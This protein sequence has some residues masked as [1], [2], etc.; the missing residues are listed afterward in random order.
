MVKDNQVKYDPQADVLYLVS[1]SGTIEHSQEV[2]PGITIEHNSE[3][4]VVGVEVLHASKVLTNK[5]IASL[6]AHQ[7]GVL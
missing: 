4:E 7:A 3:G 1:K 2:S 5:V 6:H